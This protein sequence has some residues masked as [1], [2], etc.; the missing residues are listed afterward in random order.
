MKAVFLDRDGNINEDVIEADILD[1]VRIVRINPYTVPHIT[2][3]F[4]SG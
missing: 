3:S 2:L 1:G 4:K